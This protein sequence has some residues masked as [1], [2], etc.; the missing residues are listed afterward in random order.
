LGLALTK[1][2]V[3]AQGGRVAVRSIQGE[4]STFSAILP[5]RMA[6]GPSDTVRAVLGTLPGNQTILV[7]DDD[8]ATLKLA[9][10]TL[11]ELGQRPVCKD[12]AMD[13]LL[14]A[15]ADPPAVV[16]VD[17]LMPQI[18]GFEFISRL[19]AFPTGRHVPILVWT[20]KDL[21]AGERLRLQASG[22]AVVSK[23]AGGSQALVE[24]LRRLLPDVV[25]KGSDG[26]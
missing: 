17:L 21:D 7:V 8:P 26:A 11:R 3:E 16:I 2:L 24:E 15:E 22:A 19:R 10:L 5:L 25:D 13:A 4:G 12:N 1:R 14:A 18:D 23:R 20:V 9:D 6:M